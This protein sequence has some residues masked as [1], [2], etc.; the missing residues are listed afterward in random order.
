MSVRR[1]FVVLSAVGALTLL[2]GVR[3]PAMFRVAEVPTASAEGGEGDGVRPHVAAVASP[4]RVE[5]RSEEIR[6]GTEITGKVRSLLVAERQ[7]VEQSEALVVLENSSTSR[8]S[9]LRGPWLRKGSSAP[10]LSLPE[11]G[12]RSARGRSRDR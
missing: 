6:V 3:A 5:P 2:V 7:Q 4:G 12:I 10:K 11:R 1:N 8:D 9:R